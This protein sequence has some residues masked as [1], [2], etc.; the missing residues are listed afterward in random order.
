MRLLRDGQRRTVY[1]RLLL[2]VYAGIWIARVIGGRLTKV[3]FIAFYTAGTFVHEGRAAS[4][5]DLGAQRAF[6]DA[7]G[8]GVV[9]Y[10]VNPPIGAWAFA[11]LSRLPYPIAAVAFMIAGC[12]FFALALVTLR[13]SLHLRAPYAAQLMISISYFPAFA[14]VTYAQTSSFSLLLHAGV[15]ASLL[16]GK[17]LLA[18]IV[19]G[20][21]VFKPQ[22]AAALG[23]A[24]LVAR[25]WR[26]VAG[27]AASAGSLTAVGYVLSPEATKSWFFGMPRL[28]AYVRSSE[29]AQASF[30][31]HSLYGAS[32]LALDAISP[33]AA[34]AVAATC[35]L[36]FAAWLVTLWW[37]VPWSPSTST[38]KLAWAATIGAST[39]L[40]PHLYFYDLTCMLVAFH[41]LYAVTRSALFDDGPIAAASVWVYVF[42][43]FSPFL[44]MV[45]QQRWGV[46]LQIG[47]I[48]IAAWTLRVGARALKEARAASEARSR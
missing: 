5:Y 18:G 9:S 3:D 19:L 31:F 48:A 42:G 15:L 41:L 33:M 28:M 6:Q 32:T 30:G 25:R 27:A 10:W 1:P 37:R 45:M 47:T 16:A 2:V 11:P 35:W 14:W 24:L 39:L 13:R 12:A 44:A 29:A 43:F 7:L 23:L 22:L 26:A 4:L 17:E 34:T 8:A 36:A 21:F 38:W 40:S 46:A 20:L